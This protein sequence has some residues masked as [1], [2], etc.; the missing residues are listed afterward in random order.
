VS[1][2]STRS[3]HITNALLGVD[4]PQGP[5]QLV[6]SGCTVQF[7]V[8]IPVDIEATP[9]LLFTS[10]GVHYHPPPPPNKPPSQILK[11]LQEIIQRI[12]DV[13]LTTG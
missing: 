5:G 7:H 1:I 9:Y 6:K 10:Q 11:E 3:K 2:S 13:S 4:H 8:L 12:G